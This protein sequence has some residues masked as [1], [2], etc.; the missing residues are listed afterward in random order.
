M[1]MLTETETKRAARFLAA[2]RY[3]LMNVDGQ[4]RLF[5]PSKHG[6]GDTKAAVVFSDGS[7]GMRA[8]NKTVGFR[9]AVKM[10][11][12]CDRHDICECVNILQRLDAMGLPVERPAN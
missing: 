5:S 3:R 6:W 7:F 12:G 10:E 1:E 11:G 4:L 2:Y 9:R 8:D